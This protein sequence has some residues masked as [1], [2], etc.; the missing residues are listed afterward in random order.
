MRSIPPL[1]VVPCLLG[2]ALLSLTCGDAP[3]GPGSTVAATPDQT[4]PSQWFTDVTDEVGLDFVHGAVAADRLDMP[5]VMSG[6][7]ALLD[8]DNDGDLD[9]Y[10]TN[11]QDV[12]P[13]ERV[14]DGG[15]NR[16][17]RREADGRYTDVTAESG[18]G[19]AGYGMGIAVG[20]IDNDGWVD[21]FVTNYGPDRLYRNLG[22]GSF[23]DVTA[24]AGV[25]VDG[26]SA[27]AVFCDFDRDGFLDLYV[28]RYV[29]Y[30]PTK[31]CSAKDGRQDFCG[32]ES[33]RPIHDVLL[34]N[35]GDGTFRD[36]TEAVGIAAT[37][38]AGLGVV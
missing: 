30:L 32:P 16:L 26:W 15:R 38:A 13:R 28:N 23:A 34:H 21:V 8:F 5:A 6:G 24:S 17:Y 20:D 31:R 4:P 12:L 2:A 11:G 33:F 18:L 35:H 3:P 1:L 27:S 37:F 29:D 19:D 7:A 9:I 10:L 25:K 14:D 36:I 22:D